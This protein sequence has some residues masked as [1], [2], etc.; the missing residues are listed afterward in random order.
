MK[1]DMA[2]LL[3][4]YALISCAMACGVLEFFA[5]QRYRLQARWFN[6]ETAVD[7]ALSAGD[8]HKH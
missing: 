6:L 2:R 4:R 8:V 5:L 1:T 3:A 7:R